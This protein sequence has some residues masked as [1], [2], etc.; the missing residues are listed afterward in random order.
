MNFDDIIKI[1]TAFSPLAVVVYLAIREWKSGSKATNKEVI[2]NF[3][4][5]TQQLKDKLDEK[6]K[7][8]KEDLARYERQVTELKTEMQNMEKGLIAKIA[9]L[10]GVIAEKDKQ[11][12]IANEILANRSP[13]L[14]KLLAEIRDFMSNIYDQNMHQTSLL[15]TSQTRDQTIDTSTEEE[16][17]KVLRK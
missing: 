17:G 4:L 11:L 12:K 16:R 2:D 6:E 5:L 3:E 7:T 9:K 8:H 14:E 10:E 1:M 13:E 15:E